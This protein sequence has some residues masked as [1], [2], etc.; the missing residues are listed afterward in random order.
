MKFPCFKRIFL[1]TTV[2]CCFFSCSSDLDFEQAK[3]L[4]I[5]PVFTT[6]LAYQKKEA[7]DFISSGTENPIAIYTADVDFLESSFIEE[8]LVKAELYFRIKNTVPRAFTYD[9]T[10]FDVSNT[11]I[12][13]LRINV[14]AYDGTEA[15]VERTETF[16]EA[17]VDII[18]N[19]TTMM[20]SS[21]MHS[22]TPITIATP[23]RIEL[24]S[25]ATV[26]FE[27]E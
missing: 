14:P 19:T 5:Q 26:Y 18:K 2:I 22:G 1:I 21:L 23:G 3:D 11:P 8:D 4:K 10:F 15:F 20:F 12:Y 6:N 7:T 17:N 13:N 27:I 25:S 16:T 9:V 24:S